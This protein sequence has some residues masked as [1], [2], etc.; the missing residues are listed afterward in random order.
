MPLINVVVDLSHHNGNVNL[1]KA[2]QGGIAGIIQKATQGTKFVDPTLETNRKKAADSGLLF[3]AYHFGVGGDGEEQAEHFL[4]KAGAGRTVLRVLDFENN[5]Q[6][7]SM[8]LYEARAFVQRVFEATGIWPGLYSGHF[9]KQL[10]GAQKDP[11]LGNCWLWLAQYGP[12]AVVPA[13]WSTWTMWQYTNG[14]MGPEPHEVDGI[15]RCDR[16]KFNGTM[17]R[18]RTLWGESE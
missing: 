7:A 3:G 5:P 17:A 18:L 1:A 4:E 11:V 9:I 14:A 8:S 2:K 16:D 15:G 13:A 6:G 12:K 10:L